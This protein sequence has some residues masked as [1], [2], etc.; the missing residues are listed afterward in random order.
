MFLL[1]TSNIKNT[2]L[3]TALLTFVGIAC[4][5]ETNQNLPDSLFFR[6]EISPPRM[7]TTNPRW[8]HNERNDYATDIQHAI[9]ES[10][11]RFKNVTVLS[12]RDYGETL[13]IIADGISKEDC[14]LLRNTTIVKNAVIGGFKKFVCREFKS[15]AEFSYLLEDDIQQK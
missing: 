1:S 11:T 7:D 4:K 13:I 14:S 8:N 9:D 15:G 12:T 6:H 5:S 10:K 3:I 2:I